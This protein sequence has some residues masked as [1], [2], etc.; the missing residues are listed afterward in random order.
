MKVG[1]KPTTQVEVV[2]MKNGRATVIEVF[3]KRYVLDMKHEK[4][5]DKRG[6]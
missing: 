6:G 5:S 2:K 4:R 1:S 3:G